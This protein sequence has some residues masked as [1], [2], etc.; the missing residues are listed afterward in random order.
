[1]AKEE[2]FTQ[3]THEQSGENIKKMIFVQKGEMFVTLESILESNA[4]PSVGSKKLILIKEGFYAEDVRGKLIYFLKAHWFELIDS[5]KHEK[6]RNCELN[7][8]VV[9][10]LHQHGYF[11]LFDKILKEAGYTK[12]DYINRKSRGKKGNRRN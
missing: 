8:T 3:R 11:A 2:L 1:M 7:V 4:V 12:K 10:L 5:N 9:V 6:Y